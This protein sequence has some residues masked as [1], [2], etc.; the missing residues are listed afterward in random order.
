MT[1]T[2]GITS[3]GKTNPTVVLA[4]EV[5]QLAAAVVR[6]HPYASELL[7]EVFEMAIR[8]HADRSV[9][10]DGGSHCWIVQKALEVIQ[11]VGATR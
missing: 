6:K 11:T 1:A 8:D 5:L 4:V 9:D 7:P 10:C 3:G 2:L